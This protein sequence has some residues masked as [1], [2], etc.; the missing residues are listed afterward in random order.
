MNTSRIPSIEEIAEIVESLATKLARD[1]LCI[2]KGG[3]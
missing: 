2:V 1:I 3:I